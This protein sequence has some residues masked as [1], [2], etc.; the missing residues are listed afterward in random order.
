MVDLMKDI[1]NKLDNMLDNKT[2]YLKSKK[3]N[4]NN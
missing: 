3:K 4:Q 2:L 1:Q